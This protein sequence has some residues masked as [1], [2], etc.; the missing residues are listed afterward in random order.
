[1][2][3]AKETQQYLEPPAEDR[4]HQIYKNIVGIFNVFDQHRAIIR[5]ISRTIIVHVNIIMINIVMIIV[6]IVDIVI[7]LLTVNVATIAIFVVSVILK[8]IA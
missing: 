4:W 5:L 7:L 8:M 2:C 6:I 3:T 1:M